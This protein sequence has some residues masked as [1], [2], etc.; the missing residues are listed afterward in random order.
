MQKPIDVVAYKYIENDL[1]E[2]I[3]N[4]L[5]CPGERL[6]S[7]V[8]LCQKY[9]TSSTTIKKSLDNLKQAGYI[10]A[11]KR[12]GYFVSDIESDNFK[13]KF[14]LQ[15]N[16]KD[17]ITEIKIEDIKI[18]KNKKCGPV[19][20]TNILVINRIFYN[21]V[22]PAAFEVME[23]ALNA[24]INLTK[25]DTANWV[26]RLE[27]VLYSQ[28]IKKEI[29]VL[30]VQDPPINEKLMEPENTLLFYFAKTF[31]TN[32]NQFIARTII[33]IPNDVCKMNGTGIQ[34]QTQDND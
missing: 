11:K 6:P 26:K 18:C 23:I 22:L 34:I 32:E 28:N 27:S 13:I 1:K 9:N 25:I 20:N 8:D 14:N 17:T 5:I 24:D 19:N 3:C 29:E 2:Q 31:K 15:D 30:L 16:L 12:I 21:E 33:Y 10:Y 4:G 7:M